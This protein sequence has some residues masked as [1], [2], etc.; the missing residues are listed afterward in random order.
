MTNNIK[1]CGC[2]TLSIRDVMMLSKLIVL[3]MVMMTMRM[4]LLVSRMMLM[5]SLM[6]MLVILLYSVTSNRKYKVPFVVFYHSKM[7]RIR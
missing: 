4:M 7:M 6:C 3:V 2:I 5:V 1:S